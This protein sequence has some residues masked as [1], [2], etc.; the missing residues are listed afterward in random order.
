MWPYD[1][2]RHHTTSFSQEHKHLNNV[3][4][5]LPPKAECLQHDVHWH[6]EELLY[7]I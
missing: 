4:T 5:A 2:W 6:L 7:L 3:Y 1:E